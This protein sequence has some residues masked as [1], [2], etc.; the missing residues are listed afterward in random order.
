VTDDIDV[1]QAPHDLFVS[2]GLRIHVGQKSEFNLRRGF[3]AR[4]VDIDKAVETRISHSRQ[5]EGTAFFSIRGCF[6]ACQQVK[7]RALPNL[8]KTN[9]TQFH[10][11]PSFSAT[12]RS[13]P[14]TQSRSEKNSRES[15]E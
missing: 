8:R 5:A 14:K 6:F 7:E 4:G 13:F 15:L 2:G 3:L 1:L 10:R 9:K 12:P 11:I